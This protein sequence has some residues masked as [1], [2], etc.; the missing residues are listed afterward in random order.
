MKSSIRDIRVA[1]LGPD[2]TRGML[3]AGGLTV[4]CALG[5]GGIATRKREGDGVTPAGR[6]ALLSVFFRPDRLRRPVTLL[7][8]APIRPDSGWCDDPADRRYNRPVRLPYPASHEELWRRDHLYDL[9][10]VLDYNFLHPRR[11]AGSA[12]FFH[13]AAPGFRPTAG[14]VAVTEQAM[15]RILAHCG[16]GTGMDIR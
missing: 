8:V 10:V 2:R 6:F 15:Q 1:S 5:R 4:P 12:I 7:P 3:V 16:P 13:L 9:V 14:C 11:G